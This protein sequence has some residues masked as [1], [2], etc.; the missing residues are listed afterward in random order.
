MRK[1][2]CFFCGA[3]LLISLS[4]AQ[5][6]DSSEAEPARVSAAQPSFIVQV[7]EYRLDQPLDPSVSS[8]AVLEMLAKPADQSGY[9]VATSQRISVYN[10]T[11]SLVQV[12]QTVSVP[13][14]STQT[15]R[16][17]SRTMEQV[18]IG[19]VTKA[20]V[21]ARD[22]GILIQL[23]YSSSKIDGDLSADQ[24]P[25]ILQ[26]VVQTTRTVELGKRVLLGSTRTAVVVLKITK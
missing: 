20:K 2:A 10:E 16:G 12:G 17:L 19:V 14:G 7:T 1:T 13:T 4:P 23:D 21:A 9:E 22:D 15:G 6:S 8:A 24:L 25:R 11:E 26:T 5:A 18:E 3:L